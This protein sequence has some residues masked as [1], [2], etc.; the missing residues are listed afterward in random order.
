MRCFFLWSL[1]SFCGD[2]VKQHIVIQKPPTVI[3]NHDLSS[4]V[5]HTLSNGIDPFYKDRKLICFSDGMP[6]L[7]QETKNECTVVP[8][9]SVFQARKDRMPVYPI[10]PRSHYLQFYRSSFASLMDYTDFCSME[11][12]LSQII[13]SY[14]EDDKKHWLIF[15]DHPLLMQNIRAYG[16]KQAVCDRTT[17]VTIQ[18]TTYTDMVATDLE[19]TNHPFI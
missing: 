17:W 9:L 4:F 18:R 11:E 8:L 12:K 1:F 16:T 13:N 14:L 15:M 19:K 10:Y 5:H 6:L 2:H 3:T 7:K